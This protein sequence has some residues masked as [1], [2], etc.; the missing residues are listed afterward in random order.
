MCWRVVKQYLTAF[1]GVWQALQLPVGY[2]HVVLA[3]GAIL[4]APTFAVVIDKLSRFA[5]EKQG[6]LIVLLAD[7]LAS[8]TTNVQLVSTG[9]L[10]FYSPSLRIRGLAVSKARS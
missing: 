5:G 10:V 2:R 8:K 6:F 3:H 1:H 9:C 7:V 4:E